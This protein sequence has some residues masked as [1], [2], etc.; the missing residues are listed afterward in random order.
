MLQ[1]AR[2][3]SAYVRAFGPLRGPLFLARLSLTRRGLVRID[4]PTLGGPVF[5]RAR[6]SDKTAFEQVFVFD[7]YDTSFLEIQPR[8]II[9]GGANAGF[10]TRL[11]AL[12]YP[13]ARIFA[14]EPEESN[15]ELLLHNTRHLPAVVP[16]R[17]ALW[18]RPASLAIA[19]PQ[20]EKWAFRVAERS[21]EGLAP[22]SAVTIPDIMRRAGA[23]GVDILKLD[24]EGAE[25]ELFSSAYEWWLGR[26]NTIIIEL[27]DELRPG[28]GAAFYGAIARFRFRQFQRGEHV[29]LVRE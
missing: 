18:N 26:V 3:L 15:F 12:R 27:H 24:I 21:G 19:N 5:A 23:D 6:S 10:A 1:R 8:I 17:A 28:C 22:V 7:H 9:D 16:I 25:R 20:D 2:R 14:V 13:E 29:V 4:A 11:F